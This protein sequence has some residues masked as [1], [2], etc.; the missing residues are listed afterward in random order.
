MSLTRRSL[1]AGAVAAAPA[2][3]LPPA[4]TAAGR[5]RVEV[6]REGTFDCGVMAGIPGRHAIT[7]WTRVGGLERSGH[8]RL[9]VARDEGFAQVV[10]RQTVR[11]S[12]VRDFTARATIRSSKVLQ[13]GE[14]YWYRFATRSGSSPAGRFTTARPADSREPLRIGFFSCQSWTAGL[15]HAH[16]GLAAEP[17][18]DLVLCLG[19]Y[20]YE[21]GGRNAA[22]GRV[23]EIGPDRQAQTL[24]EWREKYRLYLSDPH[25]R[26]MHASSAF[27]G[28]WDDHEAE[29]NYAGEAEGT[30]ADGRRR[31]DFAT[32]R[33]NGYTA[34]FEY[35]P[36]NTIPQERHRSYRRIRLGGMADVLL[37]DT[38]QYR[39][40]QACDR[41]IVPCEGTADRSRTMLGAPQ[42]R[43]LKDALSESR[44]TWKVLANQVV[45]MGLDSAPSLPLNPDQWDGYPGDRADV[46]GHVR[47]KDIRGVTAVTGDIHTF[48]AG[49]VFP[50]GRSD[51]RRPAATEFV[52]GSIS[53]GGLERDF[54]D[55]TPVVEAGVVVTNSPHLKYAQL[56]RRG[57]GVMELAPDEL[58]VAFRSPTSVTAREARIETLARFRV[59][60]D[61][62]VVERV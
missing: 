44:A 40:D 36:R 49:D 25:L 32:R 52:G 37:L 7:L 50:E 9:E 20:V 27:A 23:D 42:R 30:L 31:V 17:D 35:G 2:F 10:H 22:I 3:V 53:S 56:S 55:L 18:L 15:Y 38:R 60:L 4:V 11:A 45:M 1:L 54:G 33:R 14:R 58:R 43:W 48:F 13:P 39:D 16:A 29:N 34:F 62:G 61:D 41:E 24:A 51:L 47:A 12:A 21:G 28:I 6:L 8:L 5:R 59:G 46:M 57:Y 19:D 26:A